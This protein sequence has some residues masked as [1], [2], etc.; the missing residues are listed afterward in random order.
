MLTSTV[1]IEEHL[2]R[3]AVDQMQPYGKHRNPRKRLQIAIRSG[4]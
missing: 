1:I 2:L 4:N 3:H